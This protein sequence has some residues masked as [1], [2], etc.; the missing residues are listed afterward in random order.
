MV[1][2]LS[3]VGGTS[4]CFFM[5]QPGQA[6]ERALEA[7]LDYDPPHSL[8]HFLKLCPTSKKFH[9][10]LDHGHQVRLK[11]SSLWGI[12]SMQAIRWS[13]ED[14]LIPYTGT[15]VLAQ[16]PCALHAW[17]LL[18]YA[19]LLLPK[20]SLFLRAHV[21]GGFMFHPQECCLLPLKWGPSLAWNSPL[22][23]AGLAAQQAHLLVSTSLLLELQACEA[24]PRIFP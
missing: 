22:R 11:C 13:C 7:G 19:G 17:L 12:F 8:T 16:S 15:Y 3:V 10:L 6:P 1:W 20:L 2:L 18:L 9:F 4:A 24:M 23:V 14:I 21:L 5:W